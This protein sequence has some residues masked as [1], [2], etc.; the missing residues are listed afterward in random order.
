M[1]IAYFSVFFL[2]LIYTR[3][4]KDFFIK[5]TI[6][7]PGTIFFFLFTWGS[8][9]S[10]LWIPLIG[11]FNAKSVTLAENLLIPNAI[12][13]VLLA[14]LINMGIGFFYLAPKLKALF[15]KGYFREKIKNYDYILFYLSLQLLCYS[16]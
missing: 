7:I 16:N 11:P 15:F 12:L 6:F 8:F 5:N 14:I 3:E 9:P 10:N 4:W 2:K 1:A 13:S